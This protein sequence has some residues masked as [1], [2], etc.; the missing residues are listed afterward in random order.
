MSLRFVLDSVEA[1]GIFESGGVFV[2]LFVLE[3]SSANNI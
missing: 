1:Q 3:S 2:G